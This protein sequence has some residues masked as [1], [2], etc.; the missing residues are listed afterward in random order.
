MLGE[1]KT[2]EI[3]DLLNGQWVARLGCHA[4]GLTYVVPISYA[5]DGRAVYGHTTPGLKLRM[6]HENPAVCVQV[7][8][9]DN[10]ANWRS[11]VAWGRFEELTDAAAGDALRLL[12]D[13]FAPLMTGEA[14]TPTHGHLAAHEPPVPGRHGVVFRIMLER[15]TG[16]FERMP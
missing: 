6:L 2:N 15:K 7:D 1:L 13:R 16:R 4:N 12:I 10:L 11:V 8:H 14:S 5:Y 9:V 3:E